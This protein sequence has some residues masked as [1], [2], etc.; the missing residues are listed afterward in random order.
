VMIRLQDKLQPA[1]EESILVDSDCW[2]GINSVLLPGCQLAQGMIVGAGSIV[3]G[4]H[5][6]P[7]CIVAG[8][9]ARCIG[10]RWIYERMQIASG[11]G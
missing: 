2:I 8:A 4:S 9:P 11:E 1:Q 5:R 7:Y 10:Q 3:K 6:S